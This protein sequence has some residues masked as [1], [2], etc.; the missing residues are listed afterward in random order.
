VTDG[1]AFLPGKKLDLT[2]GAQSVQ[3]KYHLFMENVLLTEIGKFKIS[4]F[5]TKNNSSKTV[6]EVFFEKTGDNWTLQP[7]PTDNWIAFDQPILT[8][9]NHPEY[10]N[11]KFPHTINVDNTKLEVKLKIVNI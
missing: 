1:S 9:G 7:P 4:A 6:E 3:K 11:I 5:T 10:T 2:V 8:A